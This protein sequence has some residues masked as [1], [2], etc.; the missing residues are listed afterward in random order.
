MAF[1]RQSPTMG[2]M[3]QS[4]IERI[5]AWLVESGLDGA[6]EAELLHGFCDRCRRSALDLSRA[7]VIID[8]LHPIYEGRAFRWRNDGV[9]ESSVVEYGR[10]SAG[11]AAAAWQRSAFYHLLT[12]GADEVR[13]RIGHGDPADFLHLDRFQAD[14]ET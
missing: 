8:T 1:L 14:G 6:E 13:R 3:H 4:D 10:T 9:E 7:A 5:V 2:A 11:E 12:T